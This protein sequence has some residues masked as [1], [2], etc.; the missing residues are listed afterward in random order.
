MGPYGQGGGADHAGVA[1]LAEPGHGAGGRAVLARAG[2]Q[3]EG[4]GQHGRLPAGVLDGRQGAQ[5]VQHQGRRWPEDGAEQHQGG[6]VA[7]PP[8]VLLDHG[9]RQAVT[10]ISGVENSRAVRVSWSMGA[11]AGRGRTVVGP[12]RFPNDRPTTLAYYT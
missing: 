3:A 7:G 9:S 11:S 5:A 1:E 2:A 12:D 10:V 8:P 4:G 6:L